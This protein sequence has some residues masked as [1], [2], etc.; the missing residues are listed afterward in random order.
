MV[1][2]LL[3]KSHTIHY[4]RLKG[5]R[6][7]GRPCDSLCQ[8]QREEKQ[9]NTMWQPM[10]DWKG[11]ELRK[12]MWQPMPDLKGSETKVEHVT[13]WTDKHKCGHNIILTN[14]DSSIEHDKWVWKTGTIYLEPM[15]PNGWCQAH[16]GPYWWLQKCSKTRVTISFYLTQ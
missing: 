15:L 10:P 9:E 8:T 6:I 14:V 11:K 16:I 7:K 1:W 4:A 3:T 2:P 12:T 13:A 5:K